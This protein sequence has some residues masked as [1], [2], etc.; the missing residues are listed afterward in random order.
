[1]AIDLKNA[2]TSAVRHLI[3]AVEE[4]Q[5]NLKDEIMLQRPSK[6][7]FEFGINGSY[8]IADH[9]EFNSASETGKIRFSIPL[10]WKDAAEGTPASDA[11]G[12]VGKKEKPTKGKTNKKDTNDT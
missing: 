5:L 3:L 11:L 1:M 9:T 10:L 2:L 4:A 8:E 12:E 6:V 7:E